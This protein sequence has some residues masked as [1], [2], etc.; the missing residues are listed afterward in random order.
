MNVQKAIR[1]ARELRKPEMIYE[2][3]IVEGYIRS[4]KA[5]YEIRKLAPR[6]GVF[7]PRVKAKAG[8]QFKAL[9]AGLDQAIYYLPK[10]EDCVR[11]KTEQEINFADRP[12]KTIKEVIAGLRQTA[13]DM[14]A[15]L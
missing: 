10:W 13:I 5:L 6:G 1:L 11:G 4:V 15:E 2:S 8:E 12:I 7:A 3:L 9:F 14:G